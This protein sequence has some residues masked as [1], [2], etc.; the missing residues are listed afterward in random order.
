MD[1]NVPFAFW[2]RAW[3]R[4][5][6]SVFFWFS[7]GRL[8]PRKQDIVPVPSCMSMRQNKGLEKKGTREM[9]AH[10]KAAR[11]SPIMSEACWKVHTMDS[12]H[13]VGRTLCPYKKKKTIHTGAT[14]ALLKRT[15]VVLCKPSTIFSATSP[16]SAHLASWRHTLSWPCAIL[17]AMLWHPPR[18]TPRP[19]GHI[20]LSPKHFN[21]SRYKEESGDSNERPRRFSATAEHMVIYAKPKAFCAGTSQPNC[22]P[23]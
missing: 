13:L 9:G 20:L 22:I 16:A 7:W 6:I 2:G 11:C 18:H 15:A 23:I 12:S 10:N 5:G 8:V 14:D 19:L 1:W 17:P 4:G 3:R 21:H